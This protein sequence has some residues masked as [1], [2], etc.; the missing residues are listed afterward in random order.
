MRRR[1]LAALLAALTLCP[2]A[3]AAPDWIPASRA[4]YQ[5]AHRPARAVRVVVVHTIEGSYRGAIAWFRN[6]HARVSSNYVV[7]RDGSAAQM[8]SERD[9]AWHAGNGWTNA[10]SVG[11]E[12]EGYA[13]I[14][15]TFTDAEYRASA[16]IAAA[17][18]RRRLLPIDRKHVIGHNEVPDPRR[19]WLG[20]GYAHHR[21]PGP[22]WDWNR[23]MAYVRAYARGEEPAP[24]R[25]DVLTSLALSQTVKGT[26]RWEAYP[27]VPVAVV[28]FLVDGTVRASVRAEPYAL[29]WDTTLERNGRHRLQVRAV[30]ADGTVAR[31][32]TLAR[33]ANPPLKLIG[34]NVAEGQTVSGVVRVETATS[35]PA[36]R[37][38][39]LID[40]QLR[41]TATAAP[42]AIDW[43]TTAESDGAHLLTVR[44]VRGHAVASRTL[45]VIVER[46][47]AP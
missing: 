31:A 24:R 44:A 35:R 7:G 45:L 47:A 12:N 18:L 22:Y 37:V 6:P 4:N 17:V 23:Y 14:P 29:D 21:D 33:V 27:S 41:G 1:S 40:G 46:P 10:H 19:P 26:T 30:T 13:F 5:R 15:W 9:I 25:L 32:G 16:K 34:L 11:I 36:A 3:S 8:V 43:D 28:D 20:G 2:A 42:Y 38:E 39:L